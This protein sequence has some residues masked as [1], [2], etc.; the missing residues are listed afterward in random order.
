M[1][2]L[3]PF[4]ETNGSGLVNAEK[5]R[6][7]LAQDRR[8]STRTQSDQ[9]VNWSSMSDVLGQ[10]FDST[11]IPISKLEQMQRD[12]MLCFG[13]MFVKVPLIRAPWYIQSEDPQRAAFI[14]N[15]LRQIYGRLIL[16]YSNCFSFGF[17]AIAKR[18]EYA[19]PD[20]K[21]IDKNQEHQPESDVWP[22]KDV[23][24]VI[25]KPFM[26][27]NPRNVAPHW[28]YKGEF[29]GIDFTPGGNVGAYGYSGRPLTEHAMGTAGD[30]AADIPLDWALWATN[31]KDSMY[32]SLWGYPRLGY[33]Y[34]Y[35][36][37]YW[38]KFGLADRAFEK[39]ADPPVLVFH[40]T[41][42][43]YDTNDQVVDLSAEALALAEQ[44]RSG[45]NAAMPSDLHSNLTEDRIS[46]ARKWEIEQMKSEANFDALDSTFKYLDVLKLR[47]MMVPEQSLM[48]GQGGSSSRNVAAEFGDIFQESQ[49]VV[50]EEIDDLINRYMIPQL[51]EANFGSGGATCKKI[52]TGFDSADLETMRTVVGAIANKHGGVPDVDVREM[53]AQMGLPLLSWQ[54]TQRNLEKIAEQDRVQHEAELAKLARESVLK[55]HKPPKVFADDGNAGV[56]EDGLYYGGREKINISVSPEELKS[57]L[58]GLLQQ[59]KSEDN[60][61]NAKMIETLLS[62]VEKIKDSKPQEP[63]VVNVTVEASEKM[64]EKP[65]KI[66]KTIVRD[67]NGDAMYIDEEELNDE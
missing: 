41:D 58:G 30:R 4:A 54:E 21:F 63:P 25:W 29:A 7:R 15:A 40:P 59:E 3:A 19:T 12:P 9:W 43:Q 46:N 60:V 26:P 10:P 11:R 14:D 42:D 28:N 56:N 61:K 17:S 39:W 67:D 5:L 23:Q 1:G 48:E 36:W 34:R 51:L 35:W 44:I 16:S 50:M 13:L 66:R 52:T 49:A 64:E 22:D 27:L 6:R 45:A 24:A 8:P 55:G 2:R 57:Y 62:E 38:Y 33:A 18:F 32:G 31:E 37:S 65:R 20:W 53:L 47:S